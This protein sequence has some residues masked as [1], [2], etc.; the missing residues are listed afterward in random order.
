MKYN[1][2]CNINLNNITPEQAWVIGFFASDGSIAT[3]RRTDHKFFSWCLNAKDAEILYKIK[4]ILGID[5]PVRLYKYNE[6]ETCH[7]T[8]S[9]KEY[10]EIFE[11]LNSKKTFPEVFMNKNLNRH[12]LRGLFDGDGYLHYRNKRKNYH[13]VFINNIESIVKDFGYSLMKHLN[14]PMHKVRYRDK[15]HIYSINYETR[16]ARVIA[17]YLYHG[18]ISNYTLERKHQ[19]Y[20]TMINKDSSELD[21]FFECFFGKEL[22]FSPKKDDKGLYIPLS[23][24][25]TND[26]LSICKC[27]QKVCS[28]YNVICTPVFKNKGVHKYYVPYFTYN[29]AHNIKMLHPFL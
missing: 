22:R 4:Y 25:N 11:K 7:L 12:Y 8:F 27:I 18:D 6:K 23:C 10:L 15:D 29:M 28:E 24:G 3:D 26:S 19:K 17:W 21:Q 5:N 14:L 20:L 1:V 2:N 13:V 9:S 16:E